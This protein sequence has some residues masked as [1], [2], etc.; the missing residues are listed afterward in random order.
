MAREKTDHES[1]MS[2]D[3]LEVD[4]I[5]SRAS[6]AVMSDNRCCNKD[7][8]TDAH[9][10]PSLFSLNMLKL[11]EQLE[12]LRKNSGVSDAHGS[13]GDDK[14]TV[15]SRISVVSI[16]PS[17]ESACVRQNADCIDDRRHNGGFYGDR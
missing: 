3:S 4:I 5:G 1:S 14:S 9:A 11:S 10:S 8:P 16:Q 2:I 15:S 7:E 17:V 13:H 12:M 6:P